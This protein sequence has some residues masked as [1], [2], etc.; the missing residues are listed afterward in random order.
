MTDLTL[1]LGNP[2]L[3]NSLIRVKSD[4]SY[5]LL[6]DGKLLARSYLK[7]DEDLSLTNVEPSILCDFRV[8][9]S[10]SLYFVCERIDY[11]LF[12]NDLITHSCSYFSDISDVPFFFGNSS[13]AL[14]LYRQIDLLP[15]LI[16]D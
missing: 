9:T 5:D 8:Y 12:D 4:D 16:I 11:E 15:P 7:R 3:S 6:F 2:K 14:D 13:L 1:I 10:R